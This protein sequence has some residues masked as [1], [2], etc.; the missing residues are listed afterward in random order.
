MESRFTALSRNSS[1]VLAMIVAITFFLAPATATAGTL[2]GFGNKC[3]DVENES[4]ADGTP[5]LLYDCN[6]QANQEWSFEPRTTF[7]QV[8]GLAGKCLQPGG[9]TPMGN[10]RL[11]IGPC[12]GLEDRWEPSTSFPNG[13]RLEH[14]STGQCMDVEDAS[15]TDGTPLILYPCNSQANQAWTFNQPPPEPAAPGSLVGLGDK[16]ADVEN[17]SDADGTPVLLY[18]CNGQANQQWDFVF[19]GSFAEARGLGGKCL[20]PGGLS[21]MGN[22]RV[23]I[24]P[25]GGSEDR[26]SPRP[27]ILWPFS[28]VHV[29]TGQC[30]DVEDG[31][32]ES[33]TPLV[34]F[35][36][37]QQL[38][39]QWTHQD[40]PMDPTVCFN[41]ATTH[42]LNG[43]R[44]QVEVDWRDFGGG[45]GPGRVLPFMSDDSGLFWF[46]DADNWEMLVKVLDGCGLNNRY[47]VFASATTD[48][49][50]TLTITD[51]QNGTVSQYSNPLGTAADA[52]TDTD[53]FATCP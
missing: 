14:A 23:E 21:P 5:V 10:T 38:N 13:F 17:E 3:A 51:T 35:P 33:G 24:G 50:Y 27:E 7:F 26:W 15:S 39:Q 2:V 49:A 48:V 20:Q 47:W 53:A 22:T 4:T 18:E 44:F 29:D 34:L 25:C 41:T 42:C 11:E 32:S 6:G 37:N 9:E 12:G 1:A 36:C 16:C 28:L 45:T 52:I 19:S 40:N 8:E 30:L 31:N 43:G 46:F